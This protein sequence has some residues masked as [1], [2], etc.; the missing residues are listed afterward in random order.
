MGA[1]Q[2]LI[3][4]IQS[5]LY[6]KRSQIGSQVVGIVQNPIGT[7]DHT[8]NL[9]IQASHQRIQLSRG[10]RQVAGNGLC[11]VQGCSQGRISQ[12][13][14]DTRQDGIQLRQ[15]FLNHRNEFASLAHDTCIHGTRNNTT[16]LNSFTR[17]RGKQQVDLEITHQILD[18]LGLASLRDS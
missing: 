5:A 1:L 10:D 3:D 15:H 12:Q 14:V 18:D 17:I 13:S 11:V 8:R 4:P 16:W 7:F 2:S 9:L 6:I